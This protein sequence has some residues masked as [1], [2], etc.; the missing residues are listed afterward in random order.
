VRS[1]RQ[2][3]QNRKSDNDKNKT[4]TRLEVSK[5]AFFFLFR[6]FSCFDLIFFKKERKREN[7]L[8]RVSRQEKI[9]ENALY[10]APNKNVGAS[11]IRDL[12]LVS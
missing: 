5:T 4:V 10:I 3:R 1:N 2:F 11:T 12:E 9:K 6:F 7:N 8:S